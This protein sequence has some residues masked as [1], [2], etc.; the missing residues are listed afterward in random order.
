MAGGRTNTPLPTPLAISYRNHQKCLANFCHLAPL[1]LFFFTKKQSQREGGMAQ[2]PPLI[3]FWV[4]SRLN[5]CLERTFCGRS[6][7]FGGTD[8]CTYFFLNKSHFAIL[9]AS[10]LKLWLSHCLTVTDFI[11]V[12]RVPHSRTSYA[13]CVESISAE[14]TQL[15][16]VFRINLFFW[17]AT[18]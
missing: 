5:S 4:L 2:C 13:L 18:C 17:L 12:L 11:L 14:E 16:R 3:R 9:Y 6:K 8:V 10:S 15:L 7:S 1:T